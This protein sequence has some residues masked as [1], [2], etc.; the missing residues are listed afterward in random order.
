MPNLKMESKPSSMMV[1]GGVDTHADTH[2]VAA[3]D[4]LGRRLGC[5]VFP[6]TRAGYGALTEWLAGH[7]RI[8]AV[9]VE[10]TGSYGAGLTRWLSAHQIKVVEVN[11]PNRAER[12]RR[13]KSDPVDAEHAAQAVLGNTATVVPKARTGL[14]E[15]MRLIHATRAGAV[16]A[17]TAARNTFI[18]TIRT[19]P[20][21]VREVMQPLTR[22]RQLKVATSYRPHDEDTVVCNLKRCLRRLAVRITELTKEIRAA[23][24]DLDRL[25]R[26]LAPSMRSRPGFGPET[27]AQLLITAGDNSDR[28]GSEAALAGLCGVS[29][30]QASSGRTRYHRLNRGGD[31]QA[32]RA[33]HMIILNRLRH[34]EPTRAYLAG[35]S[36][37]GKAS[38]HLRRV[39][40][41]YLVREV[42]QL[43]SKLQP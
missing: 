27:T 23:D 40:K 15:S 3:V 17:R 25:T 39:L 10:G 31:R 13:G 33:L 6:A 5:A 35:H 11:R 2:T 36:L 16:K 28:I 9:G 21:Q 22:A 12:R 24:H 38:P 4:E 29:P 37:D 26:Q 8:C 32:N 43:L 20:D 30:V 41:R 18:N 1:V 7:G 34:H 19:G 14:V 42:Y